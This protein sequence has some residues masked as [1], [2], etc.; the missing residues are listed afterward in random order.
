MGSLPAAELLLKQFLR[1]G[2]EVVNKTSPQ[3]N[4]VALLS[5]P[6]FGRCLTS[7]RLLVRHQLPLLVR[8]LDGWR[9]S[10]HSALSR[11]PEKTE[12]ERMLVFSKRAAMEVVYFEAAL[13]LLDCYSDDFLDSPEFVAYYD[14]LQQ[15][16]FR[17]LLVADDLFPT[18]DLSALNRVVV[19]LAGRVLGAVSRKIS[20]SHVV[21]PFLKALTDRINPKKDSSGNKPNYDVLRAQIVRL[22]SGMRHV[23]LS[24][25]TEESVREAVSF[26]RRAHPLAHTAPIKKS[27][28]HHALCDML[29]CILLPLVRSDAPQRAAA[30]LGLPALEGWYAAV[31]TMRNDVTSWMNKHAKHINDGYPLSTVLLCLTSDRDYS[32]NIDS[33]ADFLHKGLKVKEAR[34]VCVRCLVVL[35]CSYL[36]RYGAHIIKHEL[37]KWL[38][39]L[40]APVTALAKKGGLTISEMLDVIAPIAEL[41][42]EFAVQALV[43]ELLQSEVPDCTL[44]GLKALQGL[45]LTAPAIAATAA[46]AAAAAAGAGQPGQPSHQRMTVQHTAASYSTGALG[47]AAS[48]SSGGGLSAS[49]SSSGLQGLLRRTHTPSFAGLGLALGNG[50]GGGAAAAAAAAAAGPSIAAGGGGGPTTAASWAAAHAAAIDLLR[51]GVQPLEVLGV[52]AHLPRINAALGKLLESWHPAYGSYVQYGGVDP[53][54]KEKAG[55]LPLLVALVRLLPYLKPDTWSTRVRPL[56][57]LPSYTAHVEGAMRSAAVDALAGLMRGSPH[58]RN[59]LCC[60]FAAFTC[61]L[62]DDAVQATRDSQALLRQLMELWCGL[63]AERA[64][65]DALELSAAGQEARGLDVPRLEGAALVC[66]ASH[67]EAVRREALQSL[68]L[69]RTL[70]QAVLAAAPYEPPPPPLSL[71][72]LTKGGPGA[73]SGGGSSLTASARNLSNGGLSGSAGGAAAVPAAARVATAHGHGRSASRDSLDIPEGGTPG[74]AANGRGMLNTDVSDVGAGGGGGEPGPPPTY[75]IELIEESGPALLRATYWDFGDW[76]DLWRLY[77]EVPGHVAFEDVLVAPAR[78]GDDLPRVRLARSLLELMTLAVRLTP[79]AAGVAGCE[80]VSRLTRMLGRVDGKLVLL[81]DY[82]DT[83]KRDAW[84][85][86]SAA[87]CVVPQALRDKTLERLGKARPPITMRDVVRMHLAIVTG[88]SAA[89]GGG[90]VPPT[91]QL[92]ST[93]SL[94]HVSPDV[95]A[96]LLEELGPYCEEFMASGR[97]GGGSKSSKAKGRADELRRTVSHVFRVL[98]ERVPPEVLGAHPLLR[99][100]LVEFMRDTYVHLKPHSISGDGFWESAQVAYALSAVVRHVGVPLRPLLSQTITVTGAGA[101]GPSA[102]ARDSQGRG[103]GGA[104]G[105]GATATTSLRKLLWEMLL[106]WTEEA[107]ILLKDIK[108]LVAALPPGADAAAAIRQSKDS[109]YSRAVSMGINAAISKHKEPPE[110]LREEL[111]LAAHYINHSTRLAMAALVEGPVFDNDTR[112]PQGSVFTWIDKLLAIGGGRPEPPATMSGGHQMAGPRRRDVGCRALRALLTHNPELFDGC[113]NKCYD[114]NLAIANGYFQVMTEVYALYPGVRCPPHVMLALILVKMVDSGPEVREDALHMLHVLSLREWQQ[115]ATAPLPSASTELLGGA[116]GGAGSG[117]DGSEAGGGGGALEEQAPVVVGGLQD[118]YQQFQYLLSCKLARDHPELSEALCEELMTR[119]LECEEAAIQH[120]VLT[121]LAP[122]MENLVISFPWRGN[123]SERLLKSQYYVTL[124]HG[125]EFPFE[126]ERLWTQLARRTRNINPI[127]DFLLHLGMATALQTDLQAML[128]FFGVAKRIVLFL[129]RV[130]PAETLGYLAIELAKQQQEEEPGGGGGASGEAGP[131]AERGSRLGGR[132]GWGGA[133]AALLASVPLVFGTSLDCMV[134]GDERMLAASYESVASASNQSATSSSHPHLHH[135]QQQYGY[136][137]SGGGSRGNRSMDLAGGGV[138]RAMSGRSDASGSSRSDANGAGAG[139]GGGPPSSVADSA[140]T[141]HGASSH[142]LR[143]GGSEY[144]IRLPDD[145][146]S[147]GGDG[148]PSPSRLLRAQS[149]GGGGLAGNRALLTR[150]ELVLCCLAE[151]VLEHEVD[152]QHLPLL[153]HVAVTAGDHEEPVVAAHAQQ[154]VINLLYSLSAKYG[155][156]G[157]ADAAAA[158]AA[159]GGAGASGAGGPHGHAHGG[160]H[161]HGHGPS[162]GATPGSGL[163]PAAAAAQL[164]MVGSLVRYLQSLRGRRMWPWEE[165][166]LAGPAAVAAVAAACGGA[167]DGQLTPSAAALGSLT[168][169]VVEALACEEDLGMEWAARALDWAQHARSRHAACRSWQVLRALRPPLKADLAAALVLSLEA[170]FA[171]GGA[172]GGPG[173]GGGGGGSGI[174]AAPAGPGYLLSG[175]GG[176]GMGGGGS[177]AGCEVAVEVISTTRVLVAALPPG[178]LVLY[179]QLWWS[180]LALLHSPHVAV[181]RAAL[182]LLGTCLGPA[183]AAGASMHPHVN[184]FAMAYSGAGGVG[185][186]GHGHGPQPQLRLSAAKVQAVLLAAAPGLSA[187]QLLAASHAA[188]LQ[189]GGADDADP[190]VL[191]HHLLNVREGPSPHGSLAVQQL[192]LRGLTHPL[193]VVPSLQLLAALGEALAHQAHMLLAR[194]PR[195]GHHHNYPLHHAASAMLA[196]S[197]SQRDVDGA[198]QSPYD[199]GAGGD[200]SSDGRGAARG[201]GAAA[202]AG[203]G[204]VVPHTDSLRKHRALKLDSFQTLLGSC[205][206]QLFVSLMGLLPLVLALH[207]GGPAGGEDVATLAANLAPSGGAAAGAGGGS[208][209]ASSVSMHTSGGGGAVRASGPRAGGGATGGGGAAGG[210]GG[211]ASAFGFGFGSGGELSVAPE[212]LDS[213]IAQAVAALGRAAAALGMPDVGPHLQVLSSPAVCHDPD[214]VEAVTTALLGQVAGCLFPRYARWFLHHV[215]DLLLGG[216][217]APAPSASASGTG[218]GGAMGVG[219]SA[220]GFGYGFLLG[221]GSGGA[222]TAAAVMAAASAATAGGGLPPAPRQ[223][224]TGLLLLRCLFRVEGLRLGPAGAALLADGAVLA[225]VVALSG[226][227]LAAAALDTMAAAM[228]YCG[229]EAFQA[230][231]AA[232][233]AAASAAAATG[234]GGSG[235]GSGGASSAAAAVAA[236]TAAMVMPRTLFPPAT[237]VAG[238]LKKVVDTLGSSLRRRNKAVRLLPFLGSAPSY[239]D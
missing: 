102:L 174:A 149:A 142:Q 145:G 116:G 186:H 176:A 183:A 130:S 239:G 163:S 105:G 39:R 129:A 9:S 211:M 114:S 220:G 75:V 44:A 154:L 27:Q 165:F 188:A 119:Q 7:L 113:L 106:V 47:A 158:A 144:R 143:G 91:M 205:R 181:Y 199:T 235:I 21:E 50:G 53:A 22:A 118:S 126:V 18:M 35:A 78:A 88:S 49:G 161:G 215:T 201:G 11:M 121:S 42:P 224:R 24:F 72:S 26:L 84:R 193:T 6:R 166:R 65:G 66:L 37:F 182:G 25:D 127:L 99:S 164:A 238:A 57:V 80:L 152:P 132:G 234:S 77:K 46:A 40:L 148:R 111:H 159:A 231:L 123:W 228:S 69:V 232:A 108:A 151:V 48:S 213:A 134:V 175:G 61:T 156:E 10:T 109:N 34:A 100:R 207:G 115:P 230:D 51:R 89:I 198:D 19:G 124:R 217:G 14:G 229:T 185:W 212:E 117:V 94:G 20:L 54:W 180:A 120:P 38:G 67:D 122:W 79:A 125:G 236:A 140:M 146:S 227:P 30:A 177:L 3:E 194:A 82:V 32:A 41:S 168:V 221:V 112:W 16:A 103:A 216:I 62:P 202:A 70:H 147:H 179:P 192:L 172:G 153:L 190:W 81:L 197:A 237:P 223:V 139:G 208:L 28:I 203:G 214:Q 55:G 184:G 128:E 107:Y 178:R 5:E 191:G 222:T 60:A 136:D 87:V 12:R 187:G 225:P 83:V 8:Q 189:D 33:A 160:H 85:N 31:M 4:L 68:A 141:H 86:V 59:T 64:A 209:A 1:A 226:G 74:A 23:V 170:C 2:D 29:A 98:S 233:A 17:W 133:A 137:P 135:Q 56:D 110:G 196:S 210:G 219:G 63:L 43:L 138:M 218:L 97:G 204:A 162:G 93:M 173:G 76:S 96:V 104:D 169:S 101:G 15:I 58:L 95:Y 73:I 13:Q 92:C 155:V 52:A 200:G 167:S 131:W 150:P 36:S 157:G 45:I 90:P 71:S 171:A 195:P 206:S